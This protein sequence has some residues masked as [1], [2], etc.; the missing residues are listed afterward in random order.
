MTDPEIRRAPLLTCP[1]PA[2]GLDAV[3]VLWR[4][5]ADGTG[6]QVRFVADRHVLAAG[7]WDAYTARL[8]H[9]E[10][11]FAADIPERLAAAVLSDCANQ[12]V[13]RWLEVTVTRHGGPPETAGHRV[14]LEE[15]QP[16][17][18]NPDLLTRLYT[19][20]AIGAALRPLPRLPEPPGA[21]KT[22]ESPA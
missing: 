21:A 1:T 7:A 16:G 15:R 12:L 13:P 3:A 6:L 4:T 18:T 14:R 17:W 11:G 2:P 19:D 8:D 20:D 9:P 22:P 5:L 10:Q